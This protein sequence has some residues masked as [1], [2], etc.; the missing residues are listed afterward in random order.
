L[1][2]VFNVSY[3]HVQRIVGFKRDLYTF[4]MVCIA[5]EMRDTTVEI[6]EEMDGYDSVIATLPK[7]F[8]GLEAEWW[9]KVVFPPVATNWTTIWETSRVCP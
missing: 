7:H 9:A 2:P 1:E 8:S 5:F 3:L 6:N 4:D